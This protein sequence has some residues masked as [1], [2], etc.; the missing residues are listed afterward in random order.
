MKIFRTLLI[1]LVLS[2]IFAGCQSTDK[3]A[4]T[5]PTTSVTEAATEPTIAID[6][7]DKTVFVWEDFSTVKSGK[8]T[9]EELCRLIPLTNQLQMTMYNTVGYYSYPTEDGGFVRVH[10]TTKNDN[11][12]GVFYY[13]GENSEYYP[14]KDIS[15]FSF[16]VPGETT[17][18]E[19][20]E[21]IPQP[22]YGVPAL[23]SLLTYLD[24]EMT[25]GSV[26]YVYFDQRSRIVHHLEL[27]K[28]G[29]R[30]TME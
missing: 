6:P 1:L 15:V 20:M 24:Y 9:F 2:L 3:P 28:D 12:S 25:D 10:F 16:I 5:V 7:I 22:D 4:E 27:E 26:V 30:E 29:V 8:T 23:S 19:V 17:I 18:V 11:V 14:V 21:K 13:P